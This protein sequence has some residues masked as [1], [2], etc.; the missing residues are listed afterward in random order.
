ML[1]LPP[2]VRVFVAVKPTDGRKQIDGLAALVGSV[3]GRD[4]LSGHLFVFFSR[5]GNIV[6]VLYWDRDGYCLFTKRLEKGRF[7]LP[8]DAAAAT[9][10]ELEAADLSLIL[11]GID[12]RGARRR[13]RWNAPNSTHE[14]SMSSMSNC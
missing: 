8:N 6:R 2:S 10:L 3:I 11:E 7:R 13:A 5:R 9:H 12:L 1:S 4:S 14:E